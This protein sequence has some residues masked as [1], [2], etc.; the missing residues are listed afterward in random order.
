MI[1]HVELEFK[2][3]ISESQFKHLLILYPNHHLQVQS[4]HYFQYEDSNQHIACRIR[5]LNQQL[6]LTFKQKHH[7]SVLETN[8]L[9]DSI[10]SDVFSLP[11]VQTFL[12]IQN[13][14]QSWTYIGCLQTERYLVEELYGELCIDKNTYLDVLDYELEYEVRVDKEKEAKHQFV[15]L[16]DQLKLVY[17]PAPTKFERF[18]KR[19]SMATQ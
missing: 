4:N 18:L 11:E 12:R 19:L 17:Q 2:Q 10:S 6:T 13:L 3:L 7:D 14:S 16:L 1:S 5:D 8:F 9:V 15:Q